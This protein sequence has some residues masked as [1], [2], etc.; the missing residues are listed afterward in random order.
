MMVLC[1]LLTTAVGLLSIVAYKLDVLKQL[2]ILDQE[3]ISPGELEMIVGLP[4][5]TLIQ[6][7]DVAVSS[8]AQPEAPLPAVKL[9]YQWRDGE[10]HLQVKE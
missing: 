5:S 4:S 10:Y 3:E 9:E 8:S 2:G 1:F 6:A 7:P